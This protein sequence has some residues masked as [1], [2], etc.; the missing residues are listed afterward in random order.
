MSSISEELLA[1]YKAAQFHVFAEQPFVL[2]I[3]EHSKELAVLHQA[4]GVTSS[5]YITAYNALGKH[6]PDDEN[7]A[8]QA[9]LVDAVS[10]L[11]LASVNGQ[12]RDPQGQW[13]GEPSLLVLGCTNTQA[14][15]LGRQYRQNAIVWCG[16]NAVPELIVLRT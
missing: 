16:D 3:G 10:Q 13:P 12:G 11:G 4:S 8:A 2:L 15:D 9:H 1:A 5:A 6:C 7:Q 14:E